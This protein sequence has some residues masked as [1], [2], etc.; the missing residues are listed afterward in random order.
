ML[1]HLCGSVYMTS[2]D[3]GQYDKEKKEL[4]ARA[5]KLA[6]AKINRID[7]YGT[8]IVLLFTKDGADG[9][10]IYDTEKGVLI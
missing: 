4:L 10:M 8:K 3:P 7:K 6:G 2:D 1:A 9:Q 5:Q